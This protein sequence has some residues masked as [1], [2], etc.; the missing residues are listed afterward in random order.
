MFNN[1]FQL[2]AEEI[3]STGNVVQHKIANTDIFLDSTSS[4]LEDKNCDKGVS[5]I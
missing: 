4:W 1:S 2:H 5:A 3:I